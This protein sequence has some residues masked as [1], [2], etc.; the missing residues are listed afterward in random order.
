MPGPAFETDEVEKL[1][2]KA[3]SSGKEMPFAFGLASKPE[4]CGLVLHMRKP[5]KTLR[6]QVKKDP[7]IKKTCFGVLRIDGA[8][9]FFQPQRPLKGM[10]AQ[11]KKKFRAEGLGK[12]KPVL[13][14]A[15]GAVIDED[16]LPEAEED[17]D[18]IDLTAAETPVEDKG[19]DVTEGPSP[20]DLKKRLVV[21]SGQVKSLTSLEHIAALGGALRKCVK[22][23]GARDFEGCALGLAKLEAALTQVTKSAPPATDAPNQA[24]LAEQLKK[25]LIA[26]VGKIK[27]LPPQQAAPLAVQVKEI[28]EQIKSGELDD[29]KSNLKALALAIA[30][31]QEPGPASIGDPMKIWQDAKE[32]VDAGVSKLQVVLKGM[33]HPVLAQIA[34]SGLAGVTD[35]N[36]TAMMKALFEMKGAVGEGRTKAGKSLLAQVGAYAAFLKEDQIIDLIENNPFGVK[37]P[38]KAPLMGALREIAV[39]AKAA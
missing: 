22:L 26:Q 10:V 5:G 19:D 38:V 17:E 16:A 9:V 11:L 3:K 12:Y 36:Q 35:G 18:D 13:L 34:D 4:E 8:E 21:A 2:K 28:S 32:S 37:A 31:P 25:I 1:L 14:G 6:E 29:A 20:D 30:A 39:I 23:L 7:A 15:D 27:S 24:N 33:G